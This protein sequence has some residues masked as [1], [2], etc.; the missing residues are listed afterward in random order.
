MLKPVVLKPRLSRLDHDLAYLEINARV[1]AYK[2]SFFVR[3]IPIW[4]NLFA[5]TVVAP[6]PED[7][8]VL[9]SPTFGL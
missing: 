4:N 7:F 9:A 8:H 3:T 5:N 2:S 1:Y 6:S